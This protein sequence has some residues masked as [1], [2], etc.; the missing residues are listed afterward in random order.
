M[1][2]KTNLHFHTNDD[3]QHI[4]D[5]DTYVGIEKASE[6]G[7]EVLA[8][9]C[10]D[11]VVFNKEYEEYADSKGVLLIPGI[12]LYVGE[13]IKEGRHL[14]VLNCDKSAEEIDTLKDLE[15]YK[16]ENPDIFVIAPHPFFPTFTKKQSLMEYTERNSHLFDA[17]EHSWFYSNL[18]DKNIPARELAKK[19]AL[20]LIATSDT[21]F[22]DFMDTDYCL[23]ET[24]EK[25]KKAIF[26]SLKKG[27][28]RNVTRPKKLLTELIPVYG[29]F[30]LKNAFN[31]FYRNR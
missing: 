6:L 28:F 18:I 4:I 9:T 20:P 1:I 31:S 13:E 16:K 27:T 8:L 17:I 26:R 7:F 2:L 5:Y 14:L 10:H 22:L 19:K 23:I 3:P 11:R 24:E 21:H 15:R 29:S 25:T 12:E 30:C